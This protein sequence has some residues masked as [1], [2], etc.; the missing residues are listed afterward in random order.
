MSNFTHDS[1]C[2]SCFT[3]SA[4]SH[5]AACGWQPG[6][7]NAPPALPLGLELDGRYRIGRVLGQGGFGIT[8]LAWEADLERRLA[9]KEYLPRDSA[10]RAPN[11]TELA[12]YTGAAGEQFAYGLE[13]FL[14]EARALARFDQHPGIVSVKSFFRANG[15]GYSVMEYVDGMT[16]KQYLAAQPGGRLPFDKVLRLLMP[17]MDALRAVHAEGLLHRDV[18]P[19]NIYLSRD[20][21]IKLLDFGAARQAMG[22]HSRSLSIIL[23]PGYAPEEQYRSKGQQGPWTD[24]YSLAATAYQAVTGQL[25]PDAL[26]RLAGEELFTPS[27]LGAEITPEQESTLLMALAVRGSERFQTIDALQDGFFNRSR[28]SSYSLPNRKEAQ[29]GENDSRHLI[30]PCGD[31]SDL[32]AGRY[33]DHGDGTVTDMKTGL[34]W[35]RCSYGQ[36]WD[37]STCVGKAKTLNWEQAVQVAMDHTAKNGN[38]VSWRLPSVTEL[39]SLVYCSTAIQ[40]PEGVRNSG[41]HGQHTIPT[42][43]EKVFPNT[44]PT[45]YWTASADESMPVTIDYQAN[46]YQLV[47][48][49]NGQIYSFHKSLDYPVRLVCSAK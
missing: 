36:S 23:K 12:V 25:P 45:W 44:R 3:Q 22:A 10:S 9:I 29:S 28:P 18:A 35:M 24:V 21:R 37:G 34:R 42:I 17:V 41:C 20:G 15:T 5:C 6:V 19:D 38:G 46:H 26:D 13:R 14:E 8:Y 16:L 11:G 4:G 27:R 1:R 33:R 47:N 39:Q 40:Q 30:K 43:M 49:R 2:P 7:G 48:F 31:T 32:I